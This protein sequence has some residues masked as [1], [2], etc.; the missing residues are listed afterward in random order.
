MPTQKTMEFLSPETVRIY[1]QILDFMETA[2]M[3]CGAYRDGQL[4]EE[5]PIDV[6]V[7]NFTKVVNDCRAILLLVQQGFYIQAGILC[8]STDDA[9][10]LMMHV[11]F[12]GENA[13]LLPKWLHGQRLTHWQIMEQL[14]RHLGK[15]LHLQSYEATRR[16]LD[17][18]VHANYLALQLYPAQSPGSTALD[19]KSFS[20]ITFW[21]GLLQLFIVSCL[22]CVPLFVPDLQRDA[23]S[24]LSLLGAE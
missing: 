1:T 7:L 2:Y 14:N 19:N 9:C 21:K 15:Q 5:R 10:N 24:Y 12:E 23:N 4:S 18:F 11:A 3:K 17:D 20:R 6:L 22:L 16:K 8:R 13:I